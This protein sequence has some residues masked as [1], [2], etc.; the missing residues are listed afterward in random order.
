[1]VNLQ[2]SFKI[3][4]LDYSLGLASVD[5]GDCSSRP[6]RIG[7]GVGLVGSVEQRWTQRIGRGCFG[8]C[9]FLSFAA[10]RWITALELTLYPV[11]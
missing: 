11:C 9:S 5:L 3:D 1:M 2:F 6:V 8:R 4:F 10:S 7:F